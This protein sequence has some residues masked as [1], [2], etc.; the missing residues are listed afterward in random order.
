MAAWGLILKGDL[1]SEALIGVRAVLFLIWAGI[2]CLHYVGV[3]MMQDKTET[4]QHTN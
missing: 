4:M 3:L 1:A 2:S